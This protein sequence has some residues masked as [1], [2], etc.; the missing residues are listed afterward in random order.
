MSIWD[1]IPPD[2]LYRRLGLDENS[3][4][5]EV[6]G[7]DMEA[8]GHLARLTYI[9]LYKPVTQCPACKDSVEDQVQATLLHVVKKKKEGRLNLDDPKTFYGYLRVLILRYWYSTVRRLPAIGSETSFDDFLE[10]ILSFDGGINRSEN[11]LIFQKLLETIC[12]GS[13]LKEEHRLALKYYLM[14][15]SGNPE[16]TSREGLA[17][18]LSEELGKKITVSSADQYV[19]RAKKEIR[20]IFFPDSEKK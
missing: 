1:Q 9:I 6:A 17:Q 18:K 10:N 14:K 2:V 15:E 20:A 5:S 13:E 7:E 12:F 19:C 4:A 8:W 16:V 3:S 11:L